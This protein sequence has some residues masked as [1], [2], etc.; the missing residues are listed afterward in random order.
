[1]VGKLAT[2]G[3][4]KDNIKCVIVCVYARVC[5]CVR[6]RACVCKI[7]DRIVILLCYV[8]TVWPSLSSSCSE[9]HKL[10]SVWEAFLGR[11]SLKCFYD[12]FVCFSI[13]QKS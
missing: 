13:T 8:L 3:L 5:A 2:E 6:V 11:G 9:Q 1:M 12:T 10:Q 4:K 7:K